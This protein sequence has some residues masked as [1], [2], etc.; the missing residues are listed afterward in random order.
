MKLTR[1]EFLRLAALAAIS[2]AT[3]CGGSGGV[4]EDNP[5][6]VLG[7]LDGYKNYANLF[8]D[9][10][11]H[12]NVSDGDESPD[13]ALR[14]ARDVSKLDFCCLTDHAEMMVNDGLVL[15]P[16]YRS[17]PAK[18][19]DAGKFCVL[20]GFEWTSNYFGHRNVYSLDNTIPICSCQVDETKTPEQLWAAL[21]GHD[22]IAVPHHP[23]I[24][25]ME[26]WWDHYNPDIERLVEFYSKW[27]LSL[28]PGNDR[29]L[30]NRR[31]DNAV[32]TAFDAGKRYGLICSTDTHLSRPASRLAEVRPG[33]LEHPEPGIV[34]VWAANH[35]RQAIFDA[36]KNRRCYGTTGTRVKMQFSVNNALMG[37]SI[38]SMTQPV[39]DFY[40]SSPVNITGISVVKFSGGSHITLKSYHPN[41]L[42]SAGRFTDENFIEDASYILRVDL[43]NTD[44]ALTSPVWVEKVNSGNII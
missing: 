15:L 6:V 31:D 19:D 18:Y 3:G 14:Y 39:I 41:S 44:M 38:Q 32:Y 7:P 42:E 5:P 33:A 36:L 27:G 9:I 40:V 10:H 12:T 29:P 4:Q 1:T 24:Q 37:S 21:A 28:Y 22:V 20:Y 34:S 43:A 16:Y 30:L 8:G 17:L 25:S 13:F 2:A 11:V 26:K 23:M 35:T